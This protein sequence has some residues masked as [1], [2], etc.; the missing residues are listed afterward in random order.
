VRS[1]T[2]VGRER[3]LERVRAFLAFGAGALVLEGEA[4]IGK[5]TVWLEGI[6]EARERG[7]RVLVARP[8]EA[9]TALPYTALADLLEP[10]IEEAR[11][12]MP[13]PQRTALDVALMRGDGGSTQARDVAAATL[14]AVRTLAEDGTL[15]VAIDDTQWVD[16]ASAVALGYAIRRLVAERILFLATERLGCERGLRVAEAERVSIAPLG[17]DE[18]ARIVR[19]RL[20]VE[21]HRSA[22]LRLAERSG[23]N[24]F[25]A[26]ELARDGRLLED[27]DAPLPPSLDALLHARV[28]SKRAVCDALLVASSHAAPTSDLLTRAG[29]TPRALEGA[30]GLGLLVDAGDRLRFSHP[31]FASAVLARVPAARRREVHARLA[32]ALDDPD[33]RALHVARATVDPDEEIAAA[34]EEATERIARRHAA[35]EA[36]ELAARAVPRCVEC[37]RGTFDLR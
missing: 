17:P 33:E 25:F 22:L 29:V 1:G 30:L 24:P 20:G 7:V 14:T 15:V 26:L 8:A 10:A 16:D 21:V 36:M 35:K 13:A 37:G 34:L 31:L 12:W 2:V 19:D 5:T 11:R 18:I 4:G 28:A 6:Q 3:E 23:G 32:A 27:P 9:E